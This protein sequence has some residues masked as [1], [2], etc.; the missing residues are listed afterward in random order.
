MPD[1][2]HALE[3]TITADVTRALREDMGQG[4]LTAKLVPEGRTAKARLLTRQ[5]G[6][7]CGV[8]WFNRTFQELDYGTVLDDT[9]LLTKGGMRAEDAREIQ[10]I[11][12]DVKTK[13][14]VDLQ[15]GARTSEP[16]SAGIDGVAKRE[17]IKP[18]AISTLD[19]L[20]GG[21]ESLAGRA[22][23]F[24]PKMPPP[25]VL[26]GLE[27][28]SP[29]ITSKLQARYADQAKLWKEFQDEN[30]SLRTIVEGST[31]SKDGITVVVERPGYTLAKDAPELAAKVP[32][33][34]PFAYLE[35]LDDPAF[36]E[37]R[38][39]S[40]PRAAELKQTLSRYPDNGHTRL[41]VEEKNGT[42][43]FIEG[44]QNKPIISDLDLE[45]AE[46]VGGWP[47]GKRGQIETYVNARMKQVERFPQH[48]WSDAAIDVPADYAEVAA[49]FRLTTAN[50]AA[51]RG[52]AEQYERRF[53][54]MARLLRDKAAKAV[55]PEVRQAL[56]D[57]A[58][59]FDA[60][61]ADELL[62]KYPPGEK[63]IVI[64]AGDIR[65]GSS[66]PAKP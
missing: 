42:T 14:G 18:K 12:R 53:K 51:A 17:F 3:E 52:V 23:V 43:T 13:F 47:P 27:A 15:I 26:K 24:E 4:D 49:K 62:K 32:G 64:T 37:A 40:E 41:L 20:L 46:P 1:A 36:L 33:Q 45:F 50:P 19:K 9:T 29:G 57:K 6:V 65:V 38:G 59:K 44:L 8:E 2:F 60:L 31:K 7:L 54:T 21:E 5:S 66:T 63:V 48:G 55:S 56:L 30:S 58:A 22:S 10:S 11:A 25:E 28:R 16:L 35:Q 61:T 39:I 34:R